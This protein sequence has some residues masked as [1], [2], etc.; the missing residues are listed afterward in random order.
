MNIPHITSAAHFTF[1][2]IS[3]GFDCSFI[4]E[5]IKHR[6]LTVVDCAQECDKIKRVYYQLKN[7]TFPYAQSSSPDMSEI[8][9]PPIL[10]RIKPS[11]LAANKVEVTMLILY[12]NNCF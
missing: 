3:R 7:Q 10:I 12:S 5:V 9:T 6:M 11:K 2:P 1:F 8:E 4:V